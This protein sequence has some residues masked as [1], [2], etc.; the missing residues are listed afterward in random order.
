MTIAIPN[1]V[2]RGSAMTDWRDRSSAARSEEGTKKVQRSDAHVDRTAEYRKW[3]R[4]F[5]PEFLVCDID[6]VEYRMVNGVAVPVA[7]IELSRVDSDSDVPDSYRKSAWDRFSERDSQSKIIAAVAE[8]AG[9]PA[10]FVLFWRKLSEFWTHEVYVPGRAPI[11]KWFGPA[12]PDVY[13]E[14]IMKLGGGDE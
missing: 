9:V 2:L 10:Y 3:H 11:D 14:W 6:Q 8:R 13:R 1:G 4:T 12:S 7:I 5:G